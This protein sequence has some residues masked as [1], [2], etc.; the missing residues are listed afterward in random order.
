[1]LPEYGDITEPLIKYR[2]PRDIKKFCIST[3]K[4][5]QEG[6]FRPSVKLPGTV[7]GRGSGGSD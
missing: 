4:V 2:I 1:V 5:Q 7:S 6:V 3:L